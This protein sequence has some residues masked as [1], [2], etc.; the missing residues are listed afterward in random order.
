MTWNEKFQFLKPLFGVCRGS[1]QGFALELR[2]VENES[3]NEFVGILFHQ[4]ADSKFKVDANLF[5]TYL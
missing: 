3:G 1:K 2:E 5:C 4:E